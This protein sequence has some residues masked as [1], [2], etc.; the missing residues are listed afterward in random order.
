MA[1]SEDQILLQLAN[2][3]TKPTKQ[4]VS[5]IASP[6]PTESRPDRHNN[7]LAI[8]SYQ[9]HQTTIAQAGIPFSVGDTFPP[10][11]AN[12][13]DEQGNTLSTLK[14]N[15][16]QEG[17][18]AART[19]ISSN[20]SVFNAYFVSTSPG[21]GSGIEAAKKFPQIKSNMDFANAPKDIQ[22]QMMAIA[23]KGE[24]FK[25]EV[26]TD[27]MLANMDSALEQLKKSSLPANTEL[28]SKAITGSPPVINKHDIAKSLLTALN[29]L[30]GPTVLDIPAMAKHPGQ[31][32]EAGA[33]S[34]QQ[35]LTFGA[36]PYVA[37]LGQSAGQK[38]FPEALQEQFAQLEQGRKQFPELT[39]ATS[40]IGAMENPLLQMFQG[41]KLGSVLGNVGYSQALLPPS[42]TT[43]ERLKSGASAGALTIGSQAIEGAPRA[44]QKFV[45]S[46][47]A[48]D[49]RASVPLIGKYL[50]RRD[51]RLFQKSLD[52]FNSA[53]SARRGTIAQANQTA[54]TEFKIAENSRKQQ[55]NLLNKNAFDEY[56]SKVQS[57]IDN[58]KNQFPKLNLAD[59]LT[60]AEDL[61]SAIGNSN[62]Q[63][64]QAYNEIAKPILKSVQNE[65]VSPQNIRES[66]V[67][68]FDDYG[69]TGTTFDKLQQSLQ[70]RKAFYSDDVF[71]GLSKLLN[72]GRAIQKNP[73]V[74]DLEFFRKRLGD[75]SNF[76]APIRTTSERIYGRLYHQV[77]ENILDNVESIVS[78]EAKTQ[79]QNARGIISS[80]IKTLD[81]LHSLENIK[82]E[83][84]KLEGSTI[85]DTLATNP[86]L[87]ES[88]KNF[89]LQDFAKNADSPVKLNRLLEKY[90]PEILSGLLGPDKV[91]QIQNSIVNLQN[92]AKPP[93]V[94]F[95]RGTPPTMEKFKP[96]E[97]PPKPSGFV[98][99]QTK[100]LVNSDFFNK[101]VSE[102]PDLIRQITSVLLPR[103]YQ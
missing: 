15:S 27:P 89:V 34:L 5:P 14:F 11:E 26:P 80:Q 69:L 67:N 48:E 65:T 50:D 78:P 100:K 24:G 83:R 28:F 58:L 86:E 30:L 44:F 57:A 3:F 60:V 21:N 101:F 6:P 95:E 103:L 56:N 22:D 70:D 33:K 73:T 102:N 35:A 51:Q 93:K 16:P 94:K 63:T 72:M 79:L 75:L 2:D 10:A 54:K 37:A 36:S 64:A 71:S 25:G 68:T 46:G 53:E 40:T 31:A 81:N 97:S 84:L 39:Q 76:D 42:A 41:S 18:D 77:S 7:P 88:I 23:A 99:G 47:I 13:K 52:E 4:V 12:K 92:I 74:K 20:P 49:L 55:I 62:K 61:Q 8:P 96:S 19:L 87:S 45:N 82:P 59:S 1:N 43:E 9:Q 85:R 98:M 66:I 91:A 38:T 32:L 29:P 90:N 17:F